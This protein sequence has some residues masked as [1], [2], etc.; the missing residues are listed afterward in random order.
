MTAPSSDVSERVPVG[1]PVQV[2]PGAGV[3]VGV[4][5]SVYRLPPSKVQERKLKATPKALIHILMAMT[6]GGGL[7]RALWKSLPKE[8][9]SKSKTGRRRYLSMLDDIERC[10]AGGGAPD[11]T[12]FGILATEMV[13]KYGVE[14]AAIRKINALR[15]GPVSHTTAF[16]G[17]GLA[18]KLYHTTPFDVSD[19]G[20]SVYGGLGRGHTDPF[21]ILTKAIHY[22]NRVYG[23]E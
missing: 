20:G 14:G 4:N 8:C 22:A 7:I 3:W 15:V 12:K 16:A 6:Y 9:K 2:V 21:T 1:A 11:W 10:M 18:T 5:Q 17:Y 23:V 19:P 13:A